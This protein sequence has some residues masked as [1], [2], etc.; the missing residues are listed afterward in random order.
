V[1]FSRLLLL[2]RAQ[3]KNTVLLVHLSYTMK[4]EAP[5]FVPSQGLLAKALSA[6][7]GLPITTRTIRRHL[8]AARDAQPGSPVPPAARKGGMLD[9]QGWA[10]YLRQIDWKCCESDDAVADAAPPALSSGRPAPLVSRPASGEP[11]SLTEWANALVRPSLSEA[12][13]H[14]M[15][16]EAVAWMIGRM[17]DV[18]HRLPPAPARKAP[19]SKAGGASTGGSSHG[20]MAADLHAKAAQVIASL[21]AQTVT[22]LAERA[23]AL[24]ATIF[25]IAADSIVLDDGR[26]FAEAARAL[27]E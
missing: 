20:Q 7:L 27:P 3:Q 16:V 2:T 13:R 4:T 1:G 26:T 11:S 8:A 15:A 17:C 6:E 9:V 24:E 12:E 23:V 19:R 18:A 14:D 10:S 21:D 5:K 22:N 25:G